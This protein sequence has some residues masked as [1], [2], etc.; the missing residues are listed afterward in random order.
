MKHPNFKNTLGVPTLAR[1]GFGERCLSLTRV[2]LSTRKD[3]LSHTQKPG[4]WRRKK[5]PLPST[6]AIVFRHGCILEAWFGDHAP[7]FEKDT[8]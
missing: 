3:Q 1:G 7:V 5:I 4:R 8:F 2:G 6:G